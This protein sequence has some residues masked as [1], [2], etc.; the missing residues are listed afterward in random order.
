VLKKSFIYC[1]VI[2]GTNW[3]SHRWLADIVMLRAEFC[4]DNKT[5]QKFCRENKT[6]T[7]KQKSSGDKFN[8]TVP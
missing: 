5:K 6:K 1:S 4:R 3:L 8:V 7:K 2:E